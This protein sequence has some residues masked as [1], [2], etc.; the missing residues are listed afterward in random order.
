MCNDVT[1][2][3]F[4]QKKDRNI[5]KA[6]KRS[7]DSKVRFNKYQKNSL[8][9]MP[10]PL[11]EGGT[12]KGCTTGPGGCWYSDKITK[13]CYVDKLI[14]ARPNVKNVLQENT[15]LL[16]NSTY[17]ERVKLFNATFD[18]FEE[19]TKQIT[20]LFFRLY[21]SG[22]VD[23]IE[24][25]LALRDAIESHPNIHFWMYTRSFDLIPH[26]LYLTN[27]KLYLS[28]DDVNKVSAIRA[29]NTA[30]DMSN[31]SLC[32]MGDE[33]IYDYRV[34]PVDTGRMDLEEACSNCRLCIRG[35]NVWFN[36]KPSKE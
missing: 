29:Y 12:C 20:D 8:G 23:S 11:D 27:L 7:C 32:Y 28:I 21:W 6:F 22:D 26:F 16:N 34:C 3:K 18:Q 35:I 1:N 36:T 25:A 15:D 10:G 30:A 4:K 19:E 13:V 31:I 9:F 33:N 24:T 17:D 2:P 5:E 14:R